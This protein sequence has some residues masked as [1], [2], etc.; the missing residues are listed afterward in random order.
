VAKVP[1]RL[2][3][4][5]N[6][7]AL[8]LGLV[9]LG[10]TAAALAVARTSAPVSIRARL[11]GS[12]APVNGADTAETS[13]GGA[14][15]AATGA[16][17]PPAP[18]TATATA[19]VAAAAAPDPTADDERG[20]ATRPSDDGGEAPRRVEA[21]RASARAAAPGDLAPSVALGE[22]LLDDGDLDEGAHLLVDVALRLDG[23]ALATQGPLILRVLHA[24]GRQADEERVRARLGADPP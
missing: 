17:P 5:V 18:P 15:R 10:G 1:A 9:A 22:A 19:K 3:R 20:G 12:P 16:A 11:T 4:L 8:S 21:L 2:R 7:P 6:A 23:E 24:H 14:L 13:P